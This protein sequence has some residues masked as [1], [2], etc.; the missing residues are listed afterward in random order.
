MRILEVV[1]IILNYHMITNHIAAENSKSKNTKQCNE[2]GDG[3]WTSNGLLVGQTVIVYI[4]IQ[5][6]NRICSQIY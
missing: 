5:L 4:Y 2:P 3:M 1:H 6:W